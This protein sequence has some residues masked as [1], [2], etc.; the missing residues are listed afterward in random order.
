MTENICSAQKVYLDE[1]LGDLDPNTHWDD[2]VI[3]VSCPECGGSGISEGVGCC[4][5]GG[6]GRIQ[7][8]L[9]DVEVILGCEH[10]VRE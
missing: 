7:Y 6:G 8:G 1:L 3:L 4:S 10:E 2:Y 9:F 5:C